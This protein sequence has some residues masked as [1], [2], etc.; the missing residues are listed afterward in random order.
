MNNPVE[1]QDNWSALTLE[2][3]LRRLGSSVTGLSDV[4]AARRL[5]QDG[6]HHVFD[7]PHLVENRP[8]RGQERTPGWTR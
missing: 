4:E 3:V 2:T 5:T 6:P 7:R 1:H 8:A